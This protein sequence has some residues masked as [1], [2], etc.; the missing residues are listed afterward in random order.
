MHY[1]PDLQPGVRSKRISSF[2][3]SGGNH[4]CIRIKAGERVDIATISGPG[5]I[6]H[7]WVT[8]A[9]EDPMIRRNAV[10]RAWWDGEVNP[11]VESCLGDF[12]GQGWG[13]E[14][15]LM[16]LPLAAAPAKSKALVC[17]FPMP[18]S[19]SARLEIHNESPKDIDSFYFYVDY[20]EHDRPVEG[21]GR[22]HAWWNRQLT[23]VTPTEGEA[24]W[25]LIAPHA[26]NQGNSRNYVFADIQGAGHFVGLNYYVD[27]PGPIWY[28]E[29]DDMWQIDGEPWPYSL[30]GTGTE[31]FFN[32]AWCPSEVFMHPYF[33]YA[34]IPRSDGW[35][36][37][38]HSY[39]FLMEDPIHFSRSL[40]ASIEHG[41]NNS[42]TLDLCSVAYWYQTEPHK[43]FPTLPPSSGR[44]N[45]PE[46]KPRDIHMW[47]HAYRQSMGNN[48]QV[49]GNEW[50]LQQKRT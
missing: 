40:T 41:H 12:F 11:S 14:Y 20:E 38:T 27:N 8:F 2:D 44:Q 7:I 21:V 19:S 43:P 30:H 16:S 5:A 24:E 18:F 39:R 15:P 49:W 3:R 45:M 35:M 10:L 46:I 32:C 33:G 17:Y 37:R 4:D 47:R 23:P 36:G 29:G 1:L 22:F 9:S 50:Q 42:L 26:P 25:G 28:G 34:R 31:D 13:E 48:P 6:R